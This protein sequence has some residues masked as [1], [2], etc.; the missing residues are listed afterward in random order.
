MQIRNYRVLDWCGMKREE[1]S[2]Q[3]SDEIVWRLVSIEND[4][5]RLAEYLT[6]QSLENEE[7]IMRLLDDIEKEAIAC[8]KRLVALKF[9]AYEECDNMQKSIVTQKE[10]RE[11]LEAFA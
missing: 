2:L 10:V 5:A 4:I 9:G 11:L 7:Q 3:S 8:R 1:L 6:S